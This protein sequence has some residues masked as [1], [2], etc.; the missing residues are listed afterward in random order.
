MYIMC[1]QV[2]WGNTLFHVEDLPFQ[3]PNMPSNYSEFRN[4]LKGKAVRTPVETPAQIR[5]LPAAR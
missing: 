2:A 3:L 1:L 5:G 4:A